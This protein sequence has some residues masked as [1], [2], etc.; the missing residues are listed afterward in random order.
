MSCRVCFGTR[1]IL[2]SPLAQ[3]RNANTVATVPQLQQARHPHRYS[4]RNSSRHFPPSALSFVRDGAMTK[5][6]MCWCRKDVSHGAGTGSTCAGLCHFYPRRWLERNPVYI[7]NESVRSAVGLHLMIQ[8][9][10]EIFRV[11]HHLPHNSF[12]F[13]IV[14]PHF[15]LL[16]RIVLLRVRTITN[17]IYSCLTVGSARTKGVK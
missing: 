1:A 17:V 6:F 9:E 13:F 15:L 14:L 8:T 2:S 5:R 12:P 16:T 4:K 3:Y 7:L 11:A 10:S